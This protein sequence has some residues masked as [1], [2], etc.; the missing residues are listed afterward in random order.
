MEDGNLFH[1]SSVL[2]A[3]GMIS[4]TF[5][6]NT[7]IAED[8]QTASWDEKKGQLGIFEDVMLKET[9]WL[10]GRVLSRMGDEIRSYLNLEYAWKEQN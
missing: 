9:S 6:V 8:E 5:D 4:H 10:D 3:Y 2:A 7:L 1:L